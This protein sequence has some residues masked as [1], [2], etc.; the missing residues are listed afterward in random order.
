MYIERELKAVLKKR[1]FS[2]KVLIVYGP[3]QTGKTTVLKS[4]LMELPDS[5]ALLFNGDLPDD[6]SLLTDATAE[7]IR[8]LLG[9]KK[10]I[11]IDEAQNIPEIGMTLKRVA[12]ALSDV[13]VLVSGSSSFDLVNRTSEP[14]TGRKFEYTLL[15]LSFGELATH[16][17]VM[18]ERAQ[19]EARLIFG[20]YPEIVIHADDASERLRALT[21]SYLYKDI[22]A[23]Q[24]IRNPDTLNKLLRALSLQC[25]SEVSYREVGELIDA[26]G[27]TVERYID[28]L[29]KSFVLFVVPAYSRN[30]RN[31]LKKTRKV[32]F[33][34]C[35]IR[36]AIIGNFLPLAQRTD[37]GA[38]WENYLMAE[39]YKWRLLHAPDTR[40]YFWR[41]QSQS[42]VDL[43]EES[44]SGLAAFEFKWGDGKSARIPKAF[45][46]AYPHAQVGV[47]TRKNYDLFVTGVSL[48]Q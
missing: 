30:V 4:L 47:V 26:D 31:E 38:L 6:R 1:L 29:V 23:L 41:T 11:F 42:E 32:Y 36:N 12:D 27:K 9:G 19:L 28:V 37:I 35:G 17:D 5:P 10:V 34:D 21:G 7:R 48:N 20:S 24:A 33:F 25:G 16:T 3:R 43:V 44:A 18:A 40:A 46:V 45:T 8:T 14:L 13:Q 2:Q 39:R 22:L 15:P